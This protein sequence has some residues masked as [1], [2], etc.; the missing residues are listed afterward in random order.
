MRLPT[1]DSWTVL[2]IG[3]PPATAASKWIG[4]SNSFGP[5][6]GE[7]GFVAGDNGLFGAQRG[8]DD[9]EGVGRAAD[10]LN[11]DVDGGILDEVLP[12]GGEFFGRDV[13]RAL[14]GGIA[15]KDLGDLEID[16]AAGA[17]GDERGVS[18][19]CEDNTGADG[20][21]ASKADAESGAVHGAESSP[22]CPMLKEQRADTLGGKADLAC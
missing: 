15:N 1:K 16:D 22:A 9:V 21:E 20:A 3:I 14:F 12:F 6:F 11:D 2:M 7:Q 4:V 13:D 18:E 10:Q 17:V 5:A 19:Q 8:G